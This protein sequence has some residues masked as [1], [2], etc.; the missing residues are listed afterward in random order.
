ML[1][2]LCRTWVSLLQVVALNAIMELVRG[3]RIGMFDHSLF[4]KATAV[5]LQSPT[6]GPEVLQLLFSKYMPF[7]DVR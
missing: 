1:S 5:L 4:N 7:T 6:A 3:Q 2:S